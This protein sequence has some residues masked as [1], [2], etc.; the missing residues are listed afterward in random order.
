VS[1]NSKR[2]LNASMMTHSYELI[3]TRERFHNF[4]KYCLPYDFE[5]SEKNEVNTNILK[6]MLHT[7]P[8]SV[9]ERYFG[10]RPASGRYPLVSRSHLPVCDVFPHFCS[11]TISISHTLVWTILGRNIFLVLAFPCCKTFLKGLKKW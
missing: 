1:V 4:P 7:C 6:W 8:E 11:L 5:L 2:C 10:G 3:E 9:I